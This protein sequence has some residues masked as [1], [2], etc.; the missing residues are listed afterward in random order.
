MNGMHLPQTT[1]MYEENN[2]VLMDFCKLQ[3]TTTA[4]NNTQGFN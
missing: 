3:Y 2:T 4:E 1:E